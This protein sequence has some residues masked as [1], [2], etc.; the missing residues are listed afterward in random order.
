MP[1]A[2]EYV[3]GTHDAEFER[4]GLQGRL[5]ADA[6]H[7]AWMRAGIAS[8]QRVLDLGCGP[9][10]ASFDLGQLVGQ[11]GE[12]VGVDESAGFV[13]AANA[14]ASGRG[15]RHVRARTGDVQSLGNL[16]E[17]FDL[18]WARWVLCFVPRPEA[19]V[20][21]AARALKP[22]GRFVV[23]D[24][25]NY[26][27]MTCAPKA[28]SYARI[29]EATARSWRARGGDPDIVGRLPAMLERAG[30]ELE[31]LEVH[32]RH[33]RPGETMWQWAATWWRNYVPRLLEMGEITKAEC[34]AFNHDFDALE[35]S[36]SGFVVMPP[37]WE[38][39]ARKR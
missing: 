4:L 11:N 19:V 1:E 17:P 30:F 15:L 34:D 29:V 8:G 6:A 26:T 27:S 31:H 33:A 28:A 5:W 37:V 32:Q 39:V 10:F 22:G 14:G 38:V 20:A 9:G 16:G 36:T 7:R 12:V 18:A 21:E 2:K 3:L 13:E 23:F 35:R 24:Y 25:F